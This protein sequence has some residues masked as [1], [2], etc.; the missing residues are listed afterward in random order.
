MDLKE[1]IQSLHIRYGYAIPASLYTKEMQALFQTYKQQYKNDWLTD[2]Y[3]WVLGNIDHF[4]N[5]LF[6]K[7]K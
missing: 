7:K 4:N 1:Y 2:D 6:E 5:N 3:I